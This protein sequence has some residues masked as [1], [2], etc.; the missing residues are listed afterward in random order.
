MHRILG[1]RWHPV[2]AHLVKKNLR[3]GDCAYNRGHVTLDETEVL[4]IA[5]DGLYN[6]DTAEGINE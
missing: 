1:L 6:R 5:V 3:Q 2:Q 4:R